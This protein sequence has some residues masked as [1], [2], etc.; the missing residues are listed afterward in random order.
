MNAC[1]IDDPAYT[2]SQIT[3]S[4]GAV[5][6]LKYAD[7]KPRVSSMPYLYD[8]AE[9]NISDHT[10]WSKMG[11][12]PD[13]GTTEE[14]MWSYSAAYTFPAAAG[15]M[16]VVSSSGNDINGGSGINKLRLEYLDASYNEHYEV[17]TMNGLVA[18]P[19]TATNI[20]RINALW[21]ETTGV[22]LKAAGNITLRGVGGGTVYNYITAGYTHARNAQYTVPLG[23]TVYITSVSLSAISAK[24]IRFTIRT[25]YNTKT[26]AHVSFFIPVAEIFLNSNTFTREY[27]IPIK[28]VAKTDFRLSVVAIG[29]SGTPQANSVF[30]GW[31]E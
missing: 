14:D 7:G 28:L 21:A 23:K 9:G 26:S 12:N 16:E 4:T 24:D 20:Y 17:I 1:S 19:T 5:I 8:I 27:E 29:T 22:G 31:I 25:N 15:Q 2:K 30:R 6:D 18:V 10:A 11:Y 3:D 13:V